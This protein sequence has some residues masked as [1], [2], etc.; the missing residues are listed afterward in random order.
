MVEEPEHV[1]AEEI[2]ETHATHFQLASS[3]KEMVLTAGEVQIE[4]SND[5]QANADKIVYDTKI[6]M[7]HQTAVELHQLLE[8][9]LEIDSSDS[10]SGKGVH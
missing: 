3:E 5:G 6:R 9:S 8:Q 1:E 2:H 4:L 7:D 10:P